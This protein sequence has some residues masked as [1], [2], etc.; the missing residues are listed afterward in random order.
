MARL[1][2]I[3]SWGLGA[4]IRSLPVRA[5]DGIRRRSRGAPGRRARLGDRKAATRVG[6]PRALGAGNGDYSLHSHGLAKG[7]PEPFSL[8]RPAEGTNTALF[9][10]CASDGKC[11]SVR[12]P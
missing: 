4:S 1:A 9:R 5:H 10:R 3:G 12:Q 7:L 2:G 6:R 8:L 11:G